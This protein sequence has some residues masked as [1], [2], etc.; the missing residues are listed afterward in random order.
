[1]EKL[2]QQASAAAG[3]CRGCH[4][5]NSSPRHCLALAHVVQLRRRLHACMT[6]ACV[7]EKVKAV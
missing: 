5:A 2:L 6:L 1:M 7:M 3:S 4:S